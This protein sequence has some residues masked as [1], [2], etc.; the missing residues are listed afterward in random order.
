MVDL[1]KIF[2]ARVTGNM[3]TI[4]TQCFKIRQ[5]PTTQQKKGRLYEEAV[6]TRASPNDQRLHGNSL[7]SRKCK[8]T[9]QRHITVFPK[10]W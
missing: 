8:L 4:F 3:H 6:F 7:Q 10:A 2:V 9:L 1:E 5:P